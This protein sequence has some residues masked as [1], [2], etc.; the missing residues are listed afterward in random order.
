MALGRPRQFDQD[1]S[2]N[3]AMLQFWRH[4]YASTS[5]QDL[6]NCTGLSKSSLYQS[7]GNKST[8]FSSCLVHYQD[9]LIAD[10]EQQLSSKLSGLQFIEDLLDAVIAEAGSAHRKGCLLVNT[11]NELA[12]LD[13]HVAGAVDLGFGKIRKIIARALNKAQQNG[14]ICCEIDVDPMADFIVSGISGLRTMVKSGASQDRLKRV[15]AML[16]NT[17]K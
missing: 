11:A 1:K 15:S 16:L 6:L 14:E 17:L 3:A 5:M 7:F 9:R 8:L 2:L 12:G 4:G 10:L 13:P